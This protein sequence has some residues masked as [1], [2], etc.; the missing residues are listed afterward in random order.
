MPSDWYGKGEAP[1][2]ERRRLRVVVIGD[3]GLFV[4]PS[5]SPAS[6]KLLLDTCNWAMGRDDQLT[7]RVPSWE[8]PRVRTDDRGAV[9]VD[10]GGRW[11][12]CRCCSRSSGWSSYLRRHAL[13]RYHGRPAVAITVTH[14]PRVDRDQLATEC[15][16]AG[17]TARR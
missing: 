10:V 13:T 8:Y 9:A 15:T 17:A 11:W 5:L 1:P 6:E 14:S 3:G 4:G 2:A 16:G 12:G 7:R